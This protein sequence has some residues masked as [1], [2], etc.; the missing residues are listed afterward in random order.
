MSRPLGFIIIVEL[1]KGNARVRL[2]T[3]A[4][5]TKIVSL[6][7][8]TKGQ[9]KGVVA[10]NL[11]I[12]LV[13]TFDLD[14]QVI[15]LLGTELSELDVNV[16][17]VEKSNLLIEDLGKHI[18]ANITL[19]SFAEL[20]VL[21]AEHWILALEQKNLSEDLVGEGA[22]HDEGRVAG[23]TAKVDQTALSEQNDVAAAG[24]QETIDL[25]F[26]VLDRL[27]VGLEPSNVDFDIEVTDIC[28]ILECKPFYVNGLKRLTANDRIIG[29]SLE[30]DTGEDVTATSGCDEDLAHRSSLLHSRD[31]VSG[32]SSL[33][34]VDGIN[35][36]DDDTSTHALKSL[37]AALADITETSNDSNLASDHDIGG[38]L[39]AVDK[40]F[41]APV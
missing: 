41:S 37:G 30:V 26:D 20:D 8:F 32:N 23:S 40:G 33:E 16:V 35:L 18:D 38:T 22:G 34:S 15:S 21:L 24:H 4:V 12:G 7:F 31:L 3:V 25:G 11:H 13:R 39:D 5:G 1:S 19:A 9:G 28:G 6:Q 36:S 2:V 17:Q 29:H 14:V 10:W 27:G